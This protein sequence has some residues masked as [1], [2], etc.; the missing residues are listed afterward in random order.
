MCDLSKSQA[1]ARACQLSSLLLTISCASDGIAST[2][3]ENLID[4]AAAMAGEVAVFLL[5]EEKVVGVQHG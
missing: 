1:T 5:E 2:E 3:R 4:L